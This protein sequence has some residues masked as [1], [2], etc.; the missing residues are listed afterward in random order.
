MRHDQ[1]DQAED[2][3]DRRHHHGAKAH[4]RAENRGLGNIHP[5]V[6]LFLCELDDQGFVWKKLKLNTKD[7]LRSHRRAFISASPQKQTRIQP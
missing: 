3:G 7:P 2:E 4:L 6:A 5:G 1:G